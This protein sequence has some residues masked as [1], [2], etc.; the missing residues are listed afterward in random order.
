[1][2][3]ISEPSNSANPG[4]ALLTSKMSAKSTPS[5]RATS[6]VEPFPAV[7][8]DRDPFAHPS[9]D[10]PLALDRQLFGPIASTTA[11][12]RTKVATCGTGW[13]WESGSGRAP[14]TVSTQRERKRVSAAKKPAAPGVP[15]MS[16]RSSQTQNVEPSRM[17][18]VKASA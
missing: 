12:R 7:V 3:S 8:D 1:M 5:S 17:V 9:A 2:A 15:S 16:P 4:S 14:A 18:K 10:E 13:A 11:L 6:N